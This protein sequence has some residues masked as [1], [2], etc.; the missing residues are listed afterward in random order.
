MQLGTQGGGS[1]RVR[2]RKIKSKKSRKIKM[3]KKVHSSRNKSCKRRKN[4]K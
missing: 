2:A 1:G 3:N 4:E